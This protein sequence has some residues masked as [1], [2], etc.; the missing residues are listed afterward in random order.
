MALFLSKLSNYNCHK[1][2]HFLLW[3]WEQAGDC[4]SLWVPPVCVWEPLFPVSVQ[5]S[6][7]GGLIAR[8]SK[9]GRTFSR[10]TRW[11]ASVLLRDEEAFLPCRT[12]RPNPHV[13]HLPKELLCIHINVKSA[14]TRYL[15]TN[16]TLIIDSERFI[17]DN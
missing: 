16:V 13:C 8:I 5:R 15:I 7:T 1:F 12:R 3:N 4:L 2:S 9:H 11:V 10:W 17:N 6:K 14:T